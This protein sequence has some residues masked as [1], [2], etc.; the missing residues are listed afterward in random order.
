MMQFKSNK[1]LYAGMAGML[2]WSIC[3]IAAADQRFPQTAA[4][5]EQA[6]GVGE[7]APLPRVRGGRS[8]SADASRVRGLGGIALDPVDPPQAVPVPSSGQ[9][10]PVAGGGA[11]PV[12]LSQTVNTDYPHLVQNRPKTEARNPASHDP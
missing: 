8:P 12:D 6:L 1:S 11:V 2:F 9:Q 3:G 5:I 4:E 7:N 10:R